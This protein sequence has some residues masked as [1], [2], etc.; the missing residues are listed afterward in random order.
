MATDEGRSAVTIITSVGRGY[1]CSVGADYDGREDW[2]WCCCVAAFGDC[3]HP[4]RR[5]NGG[6][7]A[8]IADDGLGEVAD[9]LDANGTA[10]AA[11]GC[12]A[13]YPAA[14]AAYCDHRLLHR[15][16]ERK[17]WN[18]ANHRQTVLLPHSD[19]APVAS[20]IHRHRDAPTR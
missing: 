8:A 18:R 10:A 5:T 19:G 12:G 14:A 4:R 15:A 9:S 17:N 7:A 13:S 1:Y 11:A 20:G 6:A 2:Y 16:A 3:S